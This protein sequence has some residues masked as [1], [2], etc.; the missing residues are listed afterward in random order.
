VCLVKQAPTHAL[1]IAGNK[2]PLAFSGVRQR[3][4]VRGRPPRGQAVRKCLPPR[5]G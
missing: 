1:L 2:L 4:R 3:E 5:A